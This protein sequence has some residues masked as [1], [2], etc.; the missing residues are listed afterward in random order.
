MSQVQWKEDSIAGDDNDNNNICLYQFD[1]W[2]Q[3]GK[4]MMVVMERSLDGAWTG[5]FGK[6]VLSATLGGAC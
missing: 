6:I 5:A 1:A 3:I 4:R 2:W